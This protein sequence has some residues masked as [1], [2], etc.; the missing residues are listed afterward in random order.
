MNEKAYAVKV[1]NG[2]AAIYNAKSG[3]YWRSIGSK[4]ASAQLIG[5]DSVQVTTTD[6]K[7]QIYDIE[8]GRYIRSI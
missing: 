5:G 1:N 3:T 4:V 8:S 7:V 6:G 2:T